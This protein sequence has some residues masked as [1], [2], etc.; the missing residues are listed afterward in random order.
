MRPCIHLR[1]LPIKKLSVLGCSWKLNHLAHWRVEG[2]CYFHH[3]KLVGPSVCELPLCVMS[4]LAENLF[5]YQTKNSGKAWMIGSTWLLI[6]RC[7]M[8][9]I[10]VYKI[11]SLKQALSFRSSRTTDCRLHSII[12]PAKTCERIRSFNSFP[13]KAERERWSNFENLWAVYLLKCFIVYK[14]D[15]IG[16]IQ[17]YVVNL[18]FIHF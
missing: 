13:G 18:F 3:I 7:K 5:S 16:D 2:T 12:L 9:V 14:T 17:A 4:T 1:G 6:T 11:F 10:L 8:Y 15:K